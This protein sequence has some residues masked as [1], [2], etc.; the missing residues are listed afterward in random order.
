MN[1]NKNGALVYFVFFLWILL[2]AFINYK[3]PR[4][5]SFVLIAS[6]TV[7]FGAYL[8]LIRHLKASFII[9]LAPR[10]ILLFGLP[11]LSDDVY[12]FIWDGKLQNMGLNPYLYLPKFYQNYISDSSFSTFNTLFPKLNSPNYF[13]V[14]P[15]INQFIFYI[16][17]LPIFKEII[18]SVIALRVILLGFDMATIFLIKKIGVLKNW[19]KV[20]QAKISSL[21]ALNPLIILEIVGNLHF[22]GI[23][24]C[25]LLL[26]Y[27]CYLKTKNYKVAACIF[28]IAVNVKLIPLIFAPIILKEIGFKK[29]VIFGFIVFGINLLLFLPFWDTQII[30]NIS[31]S[32]GLYFQNFEF[33]AS[34]YY[35]LRK[36]G[37]WIFGY[38]MIAFIGKISSLVVFLLVIKISKFKI[39]LPI[40]CMFAL[41]VYLMFATTVHPW[42]VIPIIGIS[43]FTQFRF[44][45]LWSFTLVLS[46]FAYQITGVSENSFYLILEYVPVYVFAFWEIKNFQKTNNQY[47]IDNYL[48]NY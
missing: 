27:Y 32:I 43:L 21:Y 39:D 29:S 9:Y 10:L 7:L 44:P 12:R 17:G 14:Y 19:T 25:F 4:T 31:T 46:Y 35:V 24:L 13:T 26:S 36:I 11:S 30:E 47:F 1:Q 42:Y 37:F 16:I 28:A 41:F 2:L 15:P 45:I 3:V 20:K 22:E 23:M 33:N 6:Y 38:N 34:V 18:H 40:K 8:F 5:S 48:F